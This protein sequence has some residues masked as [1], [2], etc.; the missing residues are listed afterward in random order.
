MA[1]ILDPHDLL[2]IC[3]EHKIPDAEPE[4][5]AVINAVDALAEKLARHFDINKGE[6]TSEGKAF[7]GLCA[8]FYPK[9]PDQ[10]CPQ[11]INDGDPDGDWE[12]RES[13]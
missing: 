10:P 12:P 3:I 8:S 2:E 5:Q 13:L 7:G 4:V 9:Y 6:T 11:P 1:K